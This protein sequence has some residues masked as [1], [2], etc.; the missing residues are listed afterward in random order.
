MKP[1]KVLRRPNGI[2]Y[3]VEELDITV[4]A[5]F[6]EVVMNAW[7]NGEPGIVFIDEVNR[8]NP[9]PALGDIGCSNPC[10]EQFLHP[11]DNCNLGSLN[12]AA[13]VRNGKM[14][15]AHLQKVTRIATRLMDNVID[16]FD[17]P[18][19]AVTE[20]ALKNRRIGLGI[21]GF[22]DMLYQLGV[23]YN[24]PEG[25]A[26]AEKAM[27]VIQKAS[28]EM[29]QELA[30]EKGVFENWSGSVYGKGKKKTKM[31]NAAL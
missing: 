3:G 11:Y 28:H 10:G 14:D 16:L 24:S 6:N 19:P 26:L 21:M 31:R 29:S 27:G 17:F 13:F 30:K 2:V 22:A 15:W 4:G 12:L 8:T 5:L 1:R 25:L 7:N 18:V 9:L 20:L 23:Q